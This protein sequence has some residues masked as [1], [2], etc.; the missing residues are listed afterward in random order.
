MVELKRAWKTIVGTNNLLYFNQQELGKEIDKMKGPKNMQ[1]QADEK[2][3]TA[4]S[5]EMS[6][7]DAIAGI[8]SLEQKEELSAAITRLMKQFDKPVR[9]FQR[10]K[11]AIRI[12]NAL[13]EDNKPNGALLKDDKGELK[14]SPDKLVLVEEQEDDLFDEVV[15]IS[16][17]L[18]AESA[19]VKEYEFLQEFLDD[20]AQ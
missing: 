17:E 7:A 18:D 3:N 19:L 14:F 4:P 8:Q 2:E 20:D 9:R 1:G 11:R 10:L 13:T 15:T 16:I 6:K 5:E 12:K